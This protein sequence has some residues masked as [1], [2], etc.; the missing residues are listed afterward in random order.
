MGQSK[1]NLPILIIGKGLAGTHLG[2]EFKKRDIP[3]QIVE[4]RKEISASCIATGLMN[5]FAGRKLAL[6]WNWDDCYSKAKESYQSIEGMTGSSFFQEFKILRLF[7]SVKE[8]NLWP[9]KTLQY[10]NKLEDWNPIQNPMPEIVTGSG[11][12]LSRVGARVLCD[13]FLRETELILKENIIYS[14]FQKV[15]RNQLGNFMF[16]GKEFSNIIFSGGY[17]DYN[18]PEFEHLHLTP[19][20]GTLIDYQVE[21]SSTWDMIPIRGSFIVPRESGMVRVGSTYS[22]TMDSGYEPYGRSKIE[23]KLIHVLKE[24][25]SFYQ[26]Y[27]GWR[28]TVKDRRPLIGKIGKGIWAFNGFGSKGSLQAPLLANEFVNHFTGNGEIN[29]EVDVKRFLG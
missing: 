1:R 23:E 16:E 18:R 24:H 13:K 29:P 27:F 6:S 25:P 2:L 17:R 22:W 11:G 12:L 10:P 28:P 7:S 19:C 8:E 9:D 20:K 4:D 14:S 3:F 21:G 5:P 15:E 26:E